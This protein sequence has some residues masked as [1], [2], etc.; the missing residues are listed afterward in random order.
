MPNA[1][2]TAT[3]EIRTLRK[4][5]RTL[6]ST[7]DGLAPQCFGFWG[8]VGLMI[9]G[10]ATAFLTSKGMTKLQQLGMPRFPFDLVIGAGIQAGFSA[11]MTRASRV[12]ERVGAAMFY[13]ALGRLGFKSQLERTEVGGRVLLVLPG[14]AKATTTNGA[15]A[16]A[17]AA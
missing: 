11:G 3:K 14:R 8:R 7:V 10:G 15:A 13:G 17:Q 9:S 12:A 16:Q 4:D 2:D 1:L 5:N 6:T